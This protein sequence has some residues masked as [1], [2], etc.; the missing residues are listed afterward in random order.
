[1]ALEDLLPADS[2]LSGATAPREV[3]NNNA[4][5]M[6]VLGLPA[7]SFEATMPTPAEGDLYILSATWGSGVEHDLAYYFDGAWTYWTPVE[8]M[9]KDVGGSPYR[10][11]SGAWA[12]IS[13]GT[14][15][16]VGPAASVADRISVFDGTSGKLLKDGGK[17]IAEA[18][19]E[20][21]TPRVQAVTSS[22]TVTP[23]FSDDLVKITAQAAALALANP[24]GTAIA[25]HGIV[26]RIKDNGTAR[27]ISYDTQYR[28]IGVT[29]PTTT[30]ISKTLYLG[31]I[32]NS[33]DSKLDVVAVAQEA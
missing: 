16:V 8:G 31:C 3:V 26:I 25:G 17:T 6:E 28:A 5:R 33:D 13:A 20:A 22:A 10:F 27:A 15:D 18:I 1:M 7:L 4:R 24:T 14:G 11:E 19:L 12:A 2:W 30:V 23:T 32:W 9:V 29:L 21:R